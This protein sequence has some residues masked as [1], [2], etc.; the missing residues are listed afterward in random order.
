LQWLPPAQLSLQVELSLL[1]Q[2]SLQVQ[3]SLQVQLSLPAQLSLQ[4]PRLHQWS[5]SSSILR[6]GPPHQQDNHSHTP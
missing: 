3:P 4:V 1:A 6:I 5:C 2:L